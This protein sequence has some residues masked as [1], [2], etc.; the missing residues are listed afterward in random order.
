M[1]AA[2]LQLENLPLIFIRPFNKKIIG[3]CRDFS[4]LGCAILRYYNIPARVRVGFA[5]Y[6]FD[7]IYEDSIL[8]EYW[9]Q[10]KNKWCI[11]DLRTSPTYIQQYH[12]KLDFDLLDVPITKFVT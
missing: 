10:N 3:C 2:I 11:V 1:L 7:D 12:M 8:L 5:N 9:S 6:P 4:I